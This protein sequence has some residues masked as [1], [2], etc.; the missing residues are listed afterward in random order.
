M[1]IFKKKL[2]DVDSAIIPVVES[3]HYAIGSRADLMVLAGKI[4]DDEFK[5]LLHLP[6]DQKFI[7]RSWGKVLK[8]GNGVVVAITT[9]GGAIRRPM[10]KNATE[11]T[12]WV[13]EQHPDAVVDHYANER[14]VSFLIS[15]QKNIV[16]TYSAINTEDPQT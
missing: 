9:P 13:L 10:N 3:L 14:F 1:I 11:A 7:R 16:D 12:G 4:T 2:K 8:E 6:G 15:V 5:S